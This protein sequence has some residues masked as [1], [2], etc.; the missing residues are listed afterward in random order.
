MSKNILKINH[1]G[2]TLYITVGLPGSGKSTFCEKVLSSLVSRIVS[3]DAKREEL[4]GDA[5]LQIDH[6]RVFDACFE[7]IEKSLSF[8]SSVVFDS[9]AIQKKHRAR[10][11]E[12]GKQY[13]AKLVILHFNVAE[14]VCQERNAKRTRVVP[15]YVIHRYA[16]QLEQPSRDEFDTLYRIDFRGKIDTEVNV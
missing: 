7:D 16:I 10:F 13:D 15:R 9:C 1:T 14:V 5:S 2:L 4:Y 11:I 3:S 12:L 6:N 8:N